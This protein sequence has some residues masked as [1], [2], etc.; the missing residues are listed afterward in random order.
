M[1]CCFLL[2]ISLITGQIEHLLK[3]LLTIFCLFFKLYMYT[4]Y[5]FFEGCLPFYGYHSF[6]CICTIIF[7]QSMDYFLADSFFKQDIS[8]FDESN[9]F[10]YIYDFVFLHLGL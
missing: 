1:Y 9:A 10:P 2:C 6:S 4:L 3:C 7:S 5:L 8:N